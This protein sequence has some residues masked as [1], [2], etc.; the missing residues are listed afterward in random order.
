MLEIIMG[1]VNMRFCENCGVKFNQANAKFCGSCGASKTVERIASDSINERVRLLEEQLSNKQLASNS[2]EQ[3]LSEHEM[4]F[5]E[6]LCDVCNV[7]DSDED[8]VPVLHQLA[9]K[10]NAT[11]QQQETIIYWA[12]IGYRRAEGVFS[13]LA[14]NPNISIESKKLLLKNLNWGS[15]GPNF[16]N[17]LKEI[18]D[19]MRSNASFTD[20]EVNSFVK[21]VQRTI[22]LDIT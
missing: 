18:A 1:A 6:Q 4:C 11:A 16:E 3:I 20:R 19:S 5:R 7:R 14:E 9:K 2:I 15:Y 10:A 12:W 21:M 17:R 13:G 8:S 22:A